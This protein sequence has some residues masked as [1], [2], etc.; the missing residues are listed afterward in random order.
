MFSN[1]DE[2]CDFY[3]KIIKE[4]PIEVPLN[5]FDKIM[6]DDNAFKEIETKEVYATTSIY[7]KNAKNNALELFEKNYKQKEDIN[8]AEKKSF[9][10][11]KNLSKE[12]KI[13]RRKTK[14]RIYANKAVYKKK[15]YIKQLEEIV[16]KLENKN[17]Y[18]KQYL[19]N[20]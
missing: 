20:N 10:E 1:F 7:L 3:S 19:T 14:N 18:L 5:I 4:E 12:E 8:I 15:C 6:P 17:N 11:I 16:V 2:N 13:L 9:K